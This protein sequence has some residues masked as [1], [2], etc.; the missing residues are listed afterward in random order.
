M[1]SL[2]V[3]R[4]RQVDRSPIVIQG[5]FWFLD[6]KSSFFGHILKLYI[7]VPFYVFLF[8]MRDHYGWFYRFWTAPDTSSHTMSQRWRQEQEL[9]LVSED[10]NT[11]RVG[12]GSISICVI[13]H[14]F[15]LL[16]FD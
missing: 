16:S 8:S 3:L 4:S 7:E 11:K 2:T 5:Y 14:D 9:Q 13:C 6:S 12:V 1:N 15:L 10:C